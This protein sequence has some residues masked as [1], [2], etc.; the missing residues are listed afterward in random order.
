[1]GYEINHLSNGGF[2]VV[3]PQ[4]GFIEAPGTC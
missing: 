1:V 4:R 3:W 2:E